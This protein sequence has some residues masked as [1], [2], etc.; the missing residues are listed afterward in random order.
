MEKKPIRKPKVKPEIIKVIK[1]M[2]LV[3]PKFNVMECTY[4]KV[5][6]SE[7]YTCTT[8]LRGQLEV[9]FILPDPEEFTDEV[10]VLL[11]QNASKKKTSR[12]KALKR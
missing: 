3:G 10:K 2:E 8:D 9:K 7:K 5:T 12:K 1:E 4:G 6:P 11:R